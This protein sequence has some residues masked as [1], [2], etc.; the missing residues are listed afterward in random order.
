MK[1][2]RNQNIHARFCRHWA[3]IYFFS[4]IINRLSCALRGDFDQDYVSHPIN[5]KITIAT[6]H[7]YQVQSIRGYDNKNKK[8]APYFP[9]K[10]N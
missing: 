9:I 8:L 5:L 2:K 7:F 10:F 4:K 1:L 6:I 3:Q